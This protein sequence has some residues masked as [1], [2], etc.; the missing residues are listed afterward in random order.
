MLFFVLCL[1]MLYICFGKLNF[2]NMKTIIITLAVS[3]ISFNIFGQTYFQGGIYNDTEWLLENSPYIITGDVVL[4]PGKTLTI[5]P[6]VHVKF[7]GYYFLEIRGTLVAVGNE[8]NRIVFTS[9]KTNPNKDD[10]YGIKT[11]NNQ[12]ASANFEY[13]DFSFAKTVNDVD[14]CFEGGPIDFRNCKFSNNTTVL[15]GYTGY[16]T[17]VDNCE[18]TNNI[19]CITNADKIISNST[20]IGNEYGLYQTERIA[21][22]KSTFQNNNIAL[23]GGRQLVDSC[24]IENNNIENK[25]SYERFKLRNNKIINNRIGVQLSNYDG[26]YPPIKNNLICNNSKYNI[27]NLDDINKDITGNCWCSSDSTVIE[28]KIYDGYDNI[29]LGLLNYDI[30]DEE[31]ETILKSVIKVALE[32]NSPYF[33]S[34]IAIYPNPANEM[35]TVSGINKLKRIEIYDISGK[36]LMSETKTHIVISN[37][38]KGIYVLKIIDTNDFMVTKKLIKN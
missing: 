14:C 32:I 37:L 17:I 22:H 21:V 6:G 34:D 31:C 7:D 9:N 30:Y 1:K 3:L 11:K 38:P 35:I 16:N 23:Y 20:F 5:Q 8:S 10:W 33:N 25:T 36:L 2:K 29:Y 27:E 19:Y 28:N 26:G 13:C 15:A 4:F 18:F 24:I 12:G